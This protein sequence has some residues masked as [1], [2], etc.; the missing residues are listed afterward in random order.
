MDTRE[1]SSANGWTMV[2][3]YWRKYPDFESCLED[4]GEFLSHPRY[5]HCFDAANGEEFARLV[6]EAG[7]A[8]DPSYS[9][10]LISIMRAHNLAA[11]D[12]PF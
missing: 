8:T 3:A 9:D 10:K 4:H 11:L 2:T 6:Q 7:Y 12:A 1:W 5:A